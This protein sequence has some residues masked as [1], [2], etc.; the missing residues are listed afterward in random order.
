MQTTL[1]VTALFMGLAG[2]PHCVAMCGAACTAISRSGDGRNTRS[3]WAFQAGR[4]TGYSLMGGLAAASM[5][6]LGWLSVHSAALRPVWSLFH[7]A[8]A[9]LGLMLLWRAR[10]PAWLENSARTV[11]TRVRA[12][13][14]GSGGRPGAGAL[15]LGVVWS[16]LP[17]GLL[18]SA[19][20]VAALTSS[21]LEGAAVMALFAAGSS[22]SLMAGPWL[23]LRLRSQRSG[24]WAIR[25]AGLALLASSLFALWMGL[26]HNTAPW[27]L[28]P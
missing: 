27:C 10:Q 21:M 2:G 5:Q 17:C 24:Q 3:M 15:V 20:L 13:T 7:V 18:Y 19:L 9:F 11:W 28:T 16:L 4:L 6:G 8:A 22:V 26:M 1:A 14:G 23:W 12:V 25:L